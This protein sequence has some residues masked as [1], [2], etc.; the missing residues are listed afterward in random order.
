MLGEGTVER[1]VFVHEVDREVEDKF[2]K[3]FLCESYMRKQEGRLI[4]F[5]IPSYMEDLDSPFCPP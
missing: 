3:E 1:L 2:F 4:H 5:I